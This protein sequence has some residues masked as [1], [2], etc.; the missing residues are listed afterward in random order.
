MLT[1]FLYPI[2]I[3][4]LIFP[5]MSPREFELLVASIAKH[6]LRD[7]IVIWRGMIVDGVHRLKACEAAEVEPEFEFLDDDADP[8]S[9]VLDKNATRRT[10][11]GSERAV[12]AHRFWRLLSSGNPM[13]E[14]MGSANLHSVAGQKLWPKSQWEVAALFGV[15]KRSLNY[16]GA[17]LSG[18]GPAIPAV[19]ALVEEYRVKV[20]DAAAVVY[21]FPEVQER[22]AEAL[23][24]GK[25]RT[26]KGALKLVK[27]EDARL[28]DMGTLQMPL[29]ED[30]EKGPVLFCS[31]L[32]GLHRLVPAG[33]VDAVITRPSESRQVLSKYA[34]L[35]SMASQ[36]LGEAGTMIVVVSSANLAEFLH[37]STGPDIKLI[38]VFPM[39]FDQPLGKSS[40]P[41]AFDTRS[42]LALVFGKPKFASEAT[43]D[44][45]RVPVPEGTGWESL[46]AR[47]QD[48]GMEQV[49][50]QF[51][52]PG[53]VV[54]DPVLL[55]RPATALSAHRHGRR[56]IGADQEMNGVDRVARVLARA[57][58]AG[59]VPSGD[60][61]TAGVGEDLDGSDQAGRRS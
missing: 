33:S 60:D 31:G 46:A 34:G 17:V 57:K 16:A 59:N 8:V 6:G 48:A 39:I 50:L 61:S 45:I 21:E 24:A 36:I 56:F 42:M 7:K 5:P 37:A 3:L 38:H 35:A 55:G 12:C 27:D 32:S 18:D 11:R 20:S 44:V 52:K 10:M 49:M 30:L 47:L 40:G 43:D 25:A 19:R 23:N 51:T 22:A 1:E 53:Q 29:W 4:A 26:L 58:D 41:H 13:E 54:C 2:S 28:K 15:S 9:Y 14:D